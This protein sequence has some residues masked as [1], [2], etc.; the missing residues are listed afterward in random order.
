MQITAVPTTFPALGSGL[1][2]SPGLHVTD[3]I[4]YLDTKLHGPHK[5]PGFSD[6]PLTMECGFLWED[7]L[8]H[9]LADRYVIRPPELTCD[10]IALSP[11]GIGPDPDGLVPAVLEEYKF[12]WMSTNKPPEKVWRWMIQIQCYLHAT[13]LTVA[14]LRVLYVMGD[15]R[16]SGP[17]YRVFRLTFTPDE[18]L[19]TWT[20]ILNYKKET[21]Q[22]LQN[23]PRQ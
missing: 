7:L 3:V 13:Q 20:M 12:T 8:G 2:R 23:N 10:G 21:E 4:H 18:L 16:G 15:Y 6:L 1:P 19:Q 11:D 17:L 22:W 14:L 5:G 9:I